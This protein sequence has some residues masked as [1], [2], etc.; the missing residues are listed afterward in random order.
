MGPKHLQALNQKSCCILITE[1]GE[2]YILAGVHLALIPSVAWWLMLGKTIS[3]SNYDRNDRNAGWMGPLNF[4]L[5]V[6][7]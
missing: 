4:A 5:Q 7:F 1:K 2:S 6:M 3:G